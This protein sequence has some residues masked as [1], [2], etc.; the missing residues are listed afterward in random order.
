MPTPFFFFLGLM[1]TANEKKTVRSNNGEL[2][3]S[4]PVKLALDVFDAVL[5]TMQMSLELSIS[6]ASTKLF[7]RGVITEDIH[8]QIF[9]KTY[10]GSATRSKYLVTRVYKKIK[11]ADKEDPSHKKAKEIIATF[12]GALRE[13][14]ALAE[15]A[16]AVGK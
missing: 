2:D 9:D 16:D 13:D 8:D 14:A 12:A 15:A 10:K 1:A 3:V 7:A 6:E 5:P 4:P 11:K